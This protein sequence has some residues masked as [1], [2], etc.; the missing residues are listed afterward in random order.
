L[1]IEFPTAAGTTQSPHQS[2]SF[3]SCPD[4]HLSVGRQQ[5]ETEPGATEMSVEISDKEQEYAVKR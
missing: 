5:G 3:I 2:C 4:P 1:A